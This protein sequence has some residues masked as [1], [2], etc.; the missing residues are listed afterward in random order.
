[1]LLRTSSINTFTL[2]P[3]I[4]LL[5]VCPSLLAPS[6]FS[7]YM[8]LSL[9]YQQFNHFLDTPQLHHISAFLPLYHHCQEPFL[10]LT[11][12]FLLS[13]PSP[14]PPVDMAALILV[15]HRFKMLFPYLLYHL[16]P[17]C[18][19]PSLPLILLVTR[20]SPISFNFFPEVLLF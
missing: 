10:V 20:S 3:F 14:P 1:M 16:I 5:P 13:Y 15:H 2:P 7:G 12:L 11:L 18:K 9:K 8:E 4:Y 19:Y 6:P 17:F